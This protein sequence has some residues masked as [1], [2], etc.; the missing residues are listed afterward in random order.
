MIFL[1]LVRKIM[2]FVSDLGVYT[3]FSSSEASIVN[4]GAPAEIDGMSPDEDRAL[5]RIVQESVNNVLRHSG[6]TAI[7]VS[8]TTNGRDVNLEI[9]DNGRGMTAEE[10]QQAE[11]A[12]S[13]GVGIS[14]MRE[15]VLALGGTMTVASTHHGVTVEALIPCGIRQLHAAAEPI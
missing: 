1:Y 8:L 9:A 13:L 3:H 11:G 15:R 10:L 6:G 7:T 14:G 12:A 2:I 4:F 5:F